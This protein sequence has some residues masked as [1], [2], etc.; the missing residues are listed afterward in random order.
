M[1]YIKGKIFLI[2]I[3]VSYFIIL[4]LRVGTVKVFDD[5]EVEESNYKI[6]YK[7]VRTLIY[8]QLYNF[9][10]KLNDNLNAEKL[11]NYS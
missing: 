3:I 11:D 8:E 5:V 4:N 6:N 10:Q 9:K 7:Y 2:I 1:E